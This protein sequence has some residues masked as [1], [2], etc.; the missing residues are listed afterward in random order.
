MTREVTG[1]DVKSLHVFSDE[2]TVVPMS[3]SIEAMAMYNFPKMLCRTG[4]SH[5]PPQDTE[6]IAIIRDFLFDIWKI[7][8]H[9]RKEII[10]ED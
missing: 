1:I 6:A 4:D 9:K 7:K 3:S 2:D 5:D 10:L 8:F